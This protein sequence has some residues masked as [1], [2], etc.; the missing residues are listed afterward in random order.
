MNNIPESVAKEWEEE[1]EIYA[2][3]HTCSKRNFKGRSLNWLKVKTDYLSGRQDEYTKQIDNVEKLKKIIE[4]DHAVKHEYVERIQ[5]KDAEIERLKG[6]INE[7]WRKAMDYVE[8]DE[9][10]DVSN[11][12]WEELHGW[13][14]F[15]TKHNI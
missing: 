7:A 9:Q 11:E 6:L 5:S 10:G 13:Q 1:A 8:N 3:N 4:D 2:D 12:K 14:A 15:K